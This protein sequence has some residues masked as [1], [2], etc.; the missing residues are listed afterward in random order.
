MTKTDN[1]KKKKKL[2]LLNSGIIG[3]P[4]VRKVFGNNKI[5]LDNHSK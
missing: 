1:N 3:V 2:S 4:M 5:T